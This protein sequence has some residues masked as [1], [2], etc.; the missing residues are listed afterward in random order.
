MRSFT[1]I[2]I[3]VLK[4]A[5]V[6]TLKANTSGLAINSIGAQGY[7]SLCK[8]VHKKRPNVHSKTQADRKRN[9]KEI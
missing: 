4:V 3:L 1:G 6:S 5:L 8:K 7:I 2:I 9:L